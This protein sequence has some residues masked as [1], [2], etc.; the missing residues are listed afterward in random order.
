MS[1]AE[2]GGK[3]LE[4]IKKKKKL[5]TAQATRQATATIN[6]LNEFIVYLVLPLVY[7][8]AMGVVDRVLRSNFTTALEGVSY[9]PP[10]S[11]LR[12]LSCTP[13]IAYVKG[14]VQSSKRGAGERG[15]GKIQKAIVHPYR[16]T[17]QGVV[18]SSKRGVG[19]GGRGQILGT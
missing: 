1:Q 3:T 5:A 4:K 9:R 13:I 10:Q 12:K 6:S 15:R 19:E 16:R 17:R 8:Q 14:F 7:I 2:T 11:S 18:Q